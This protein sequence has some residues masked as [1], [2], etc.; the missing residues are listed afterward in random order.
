M[1]LGQIWWEIGGNLAVLDLGRHRPN[2]QLNICSCLVLAK[3]CRCHGRAGLIHIF[4]VPSVAHPN[5]PAWERRGR[6][7]I[8]DLGRHR[9]NMQ[10]NVG[11]CLVLAKHC[12]CHGKAKFLRLSHAQ[13]WWGG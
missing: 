12:L 2:M 4:H 8:R 10:F 9:P 6:L 11:S 5:P 13:A 3:L 1:N 7:A